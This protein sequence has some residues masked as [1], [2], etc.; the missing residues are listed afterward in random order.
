MVS[1]TDRLLPFH[2]R[3]TETRERRKEEEV[4]FVVE[5]IFVA[6][7]SPL[8][9]ETYHR[10]S[11]IEPKSREGQTE[12]NVDSRKVE[13]REERRGDGEERRA[14]LQRPLIQDVL[15]R[16]REHILLG[17]HQLRRDSRLGHRFKRERGSNR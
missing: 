15:K 5:L 4:S 2:L 1:S 16:R 9:L 7:P 17:F 3:S 6:L 12:V 10:R 13:R 14:H 8:R 11:T